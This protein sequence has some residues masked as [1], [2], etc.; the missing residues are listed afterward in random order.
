M[1][2]REDRHTEYLNQSDRLHEDVVFMTGKH[3]YVEV[4]VAMQWTSAYTS[5]IISFVNNVNTID[6]GTHVL[7]LKHINEKY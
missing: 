4:D 2:M 1:N 7:D 3:K 5:T 6:G